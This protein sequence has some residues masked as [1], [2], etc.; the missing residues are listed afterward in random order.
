MFKCVG[1]HVM[2]CVCTVCL[3]A[4]RPEVGPLVF[5]EHFPAYALIQISHWNPVN[6]PAVWLASL[7][8]RSRLQLRCTGIAGQ[9]PHS[10]GSYT[11][12]GDLNLGLHACSTG[13]LLTEHIPRPRR[14]D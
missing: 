8:L 13:I 9:L 3:C 10:R 4:Q 2:Q 11:G 12:A 1:V 7:L 5:L 6:Q 14:W